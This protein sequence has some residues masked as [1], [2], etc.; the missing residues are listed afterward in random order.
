M[1]NKAEN[2][3]LMPLVPLSR[4]KIEAEEKGLRES[5]WTEKLWEG[6]NV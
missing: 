6:V 5:G 4:L 3:A 2:K 1:R